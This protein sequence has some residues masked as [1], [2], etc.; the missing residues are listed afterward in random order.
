MYETNWWNLPSL[1][2]GENSSTIEALVEGSKIANATGTL[3]LQ[4][5]GWRTVFESFGAVCRLAW[6]SAAFHVHCAEYSKKFHPLLL[7]LHQID[8]FIQMVEIRISALQQVITH[9]FYEMHGV[10]EQIYWLVIYPITQF[11]TKWTAWLS[12][13]SRKWLI[14]F[15]VIFRE[16]CCYFAES[17]IITWM[18]ITYHSSY[19]ETNLV[20][21]I[22]DS[23]DFFFQPFSFYFSLWHR[24]NNVGNIR[25]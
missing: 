19:I 6:H 25:F 15:R 4:F 21:H 17:W 5:P 23:E 1:V 9:I 7:A 12:A 22:N 2:L 16:I 14:F 20:Q 11:I 18:V 13:K 8:L 10:I 3:C 24:T